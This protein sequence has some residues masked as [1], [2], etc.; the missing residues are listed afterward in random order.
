MDGH[1]QTFD[2]NS[3]RVHLVGAEDESHGLGTPGAGEAIRGL[4]VPLGRWA[5][6]DE[7][8]GVIEFLLGS[9]AAFMHGS[10]VYVDGGTDAMIR[11]DKF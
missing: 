1:W 5:E 10:I 7:M 4:P 6:A 11:P 9:G 8:A 3:P 2:Q